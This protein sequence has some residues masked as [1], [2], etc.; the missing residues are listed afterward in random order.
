MV[1]SVVFV[2]GKLRQTFFSLV[3][4]TNNL[5]TLFILFVMKYFYSVCDEIFLLLV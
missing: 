2:C 1:C 5:L 3:Y 4:N